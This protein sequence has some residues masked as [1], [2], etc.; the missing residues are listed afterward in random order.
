MQWLGRTVTSPRLRH[1]AVYT[2]V[3]QKKWDNSYVDVGRHIVTQYT[4]CLLYASIYSWFC[5]ACLINV[6][7]LTIYHSGLTHLN[8]TLW[9]GF[10]NMNNYELPPPHYILVARPWTVVV[11]L[12][13]G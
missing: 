10:G 11:L 2:G 9:L 7:S 12:S 8:L 1:Q 5:S 4:D 6:L 13:H 3:G